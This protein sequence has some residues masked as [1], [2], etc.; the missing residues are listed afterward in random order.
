VLAQAI[1]PLALAVVSLLV[2][3]L[4][5]SCKK[6]DLVTADACNALLGSAASAVE[7]ANLAAGRARVAR[8]TATASI[9]RPRAA[10]PA[11]EVMRC[12]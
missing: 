11:A 12:T 4:A 3:L 7:Q 9:R 1:A 5:G 8:T 6:K 2:P 10:P